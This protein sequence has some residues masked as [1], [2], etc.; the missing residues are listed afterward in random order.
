METLFLSAIYV[1]AG[2]FIVGLA[3]KAIA[4]SRKSPKLNEI[5]SRLT[6]LFLILMFLLLI[7]YKF[8]IE[9]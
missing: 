6:I 5:F 7:V 2:G 9:S 3:G 8:F 4:T 1:S